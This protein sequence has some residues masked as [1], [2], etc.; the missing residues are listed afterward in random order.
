MKRAVFDADGFPTAFYDVAVHGDEN[1]PPEAVEITNNQWRNFIE[2][3]GRRRWVDGAVVAYEPLPPPVTSEDVNRERDRRIVAGWRFDVPGYG[4]ISITGRE[5]DKVALTGLLLKAQGML[6]AGIDD[7]VMLLRDAENV[8]RSLRPSQLVNLIM[9]GMAW[10]QDVMQ[11][12]WDMKDATGNF[13]DGIP[14]DYT[15]DRH[16]PTSDPA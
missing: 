15:D 13:P 4:D 11:V 1:I 14:A 8:N 10:I 9:Q 6:A 12:S 7:P 2:H 16:W 3:Q 5:A